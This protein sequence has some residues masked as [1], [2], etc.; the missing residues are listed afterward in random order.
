MVHTLTGLDLLLYWPYLSRSL[1][2]A[3]LIVAM[4]QAGGYS[5][6]AHDIRAYWD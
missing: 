4:A 3:M 6:A 2:W 5:V 1:A